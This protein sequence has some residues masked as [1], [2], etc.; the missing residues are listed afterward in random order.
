MQFLGI[1]SPRMVVSLD[2]G[3]MYI[4]LNSYSTAKP[5]D[6]FNFR[7]HSLPLAP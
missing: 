5:Q 4:S 3:A 6:Y 7:G 2:Y 1:S